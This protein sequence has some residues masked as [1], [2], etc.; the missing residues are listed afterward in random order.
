MVH[1]ILSLYYTGHILRYILCNTS[2][3]QYF[4][5]YLA[6]AAASWEV[7][8]D[9]GGGEWRKPP[10]SSWRCCSCGLLSGWLVVV[11][12]LVSGCNTL[13]S[14][15]LAFTWK[16]L[17]RYTCSWILFEVF[18][19]TGTSVALNGVRP[20]GAHAQWSRRF[21]SRDHSSFDVALRFLHTRD[22]MTFYSA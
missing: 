14:R 4:I 6:A 7:R 17:E 21:G 19:P 13:G 10:W 15:A 20:G 18:L 1:T 12:H 3:L 22:F 11:T 5:T 16:L 2:Y 9:Q 8:V